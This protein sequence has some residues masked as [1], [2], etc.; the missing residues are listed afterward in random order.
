MVFS[1]G[2]VTLSVCG[3]S[4]PDAISC[5]KLVLVSAVFSCYDNVY[6]EGWELVYRTS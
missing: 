6:H 3:Y 2:D 1:Y 5:L 4:T